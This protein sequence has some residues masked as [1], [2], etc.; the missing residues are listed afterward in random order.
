[1]QYPHFLEI[2]LDVKTVKPTH[3]S[4]GAFRIHKFHQFEF[5]LCHIRTPP[6]ELRLRVQLIRQP[7]CKQRR[8]ENND[9]WEQTQR[10][11]EREVARVTVN[12]QTELIIP[13]CGNFRGAFSEE[14]LQIELVDENIF[15]RSDQEYR[16]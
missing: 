1:M 2:N 5:F 11:G 13:D 15:D 3:K 4:N 14:G 8:S 10:R 12:D 7:T 16:I 9:R 6:L